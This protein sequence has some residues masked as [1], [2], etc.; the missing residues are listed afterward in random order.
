VHNKIIVLRVIPQ[1][2]PKKANY[3]EIVSQFVEWLSKNPWVTV[4]GFVTGILG[5]VLAVVFYYKSQKIKSPL[6]V[7]KT[8][9]IIKG[10]TSRIKELE[11]RYGGQPIENL[12]VTRV[13]FWNG[14]SDT[15]EKTDVPASDPICVEVKSG[16]LILESKVIG[17]SNEANCFGI[18]IDDHKIARIT[19]DYV[20]KNDVAVIRVLHT[21]TSDKDIQI[22]GKVKGAGLV[23]NALRVR[24]M[25]QHSKWPQPLRV[26][27]GLICLFI[28]TALAIGMII[29]VFAVTKVD[30]MNI[31]T[32]VVPIFL[33]WFEFMLIDTGIGHLRSKMP[34]DPESL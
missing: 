23:K 33:M 25:A 4:I 22:K 6:Y 32:Y 11:I 27:V 21:G 19:F 15:I 7:S 30:W 26:A 18:Q 10:L 2:S 16:C 14:G 34:I 17:V 1:C 24:I 8:T 20:D 12:S 3:V 13:A 5:V 31:V 28:A 9:N 29:G